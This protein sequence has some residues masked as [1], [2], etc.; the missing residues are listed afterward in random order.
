MRARAIYVTLGLIL[1]LAAVARADRVT[2]D[3]DHRTDFSKYKTFMWVHEPEPND[4]FVK[5]RIVAAVNAELTARGLRQ[6]TEGAD[7]A[8]GANIATEE[9]HSWETYYNG[10][11]GWGW[12]WGGGWSTTEERTYEVGTLTV[13]L[14]DAENHR[15]IWQGVATDEIPSKPAKRTKE[16]DKQIEK[17]FKK[18]PWGTD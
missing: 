8:V 5:E 16:T 1:L 10:D 12:G 17:M 11:G 7:M 18:Y 4:P 13:D 14:F 6:V 3:Y 9:K 15:I 2:S